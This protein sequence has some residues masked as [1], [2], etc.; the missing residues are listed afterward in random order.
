MLIMEEYFLAEQMSS[1]FWKQMTERYLAHQEAKSRPGFK[2]FKDQD[3]RLA[4]G[5]C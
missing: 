1:I 4:C 2:A 3:N 5:Q